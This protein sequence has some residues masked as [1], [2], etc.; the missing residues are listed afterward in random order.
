MRI[1]RHIPRACLLTTLCGCAA[2]GAEEPPPDDVMRAPFSVSHLSFFHSALEI[3]PLETAVT[4]PPDAFQLRLRS[5]WAQSL[6]GGVENGVDQRFAG[7]FNQWLVTD[8]SW[9]LD[10]GLQLGGR[11]KYGGWKDS[12]DSFLVFDESGEPIVFGE[13][14]IILGEG[15]TSRHSGFTD[16][17]LYAR[18]TLSS[19]FETD[20]AGLMSVK[21]PIASK[22]DLSNAGTYDVNLG[23]LRTQVS[24]AT[25]WHANAGVGAPLGDQTLF[26]D[27]ADVDLDPWIYAGLGVTWLLRDDL[28]WGI[29]LEGNTS[30]FSEVD[31]LDGS[32][33]TMFTGL[34]KAYGPWALEGG[35]GTGFNDQSYD[36]V[37]HLGATL[38]Y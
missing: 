8:A 9:G 12:R 29:Q 13:D 20:L 34:R 11:V 24:G 33:L 32:P 7:V 1:P 6:D 3:P 31:F 16:L 21:V 35:V 10:D 28:A 38:R 18:Q 37:A 27:E 4:L 36:W 5:T 14:E 17:V 22:R 19:E 15:A 30:A 23:L 25:T 26:T 2:P